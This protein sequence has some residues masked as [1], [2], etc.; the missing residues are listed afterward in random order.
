MSNAQN[1]KTSEQNRFPNLLLT[2]EFRP[3]CI[4]CSNL[5]L[6]CE[7]GRVFLWED[8]A[9]E[10]GI[11]FGRSKQNLGQNKGLP[12][13]SQLIA[14]R[15]VK[16]VQCSR[17]YHLFVNTTYG[18]FQDRTRTP[19]AVYSAPE[20]ARVLTRLEET[21][22]LTAEDSAALCYFSNRRPDL[23]YEVGVPRAVPD[24]EAV[25]FSYFVNRI[26][27]VCVCYPRQDQPTST[28][29]PQT[30]PYLY[31][32]APLAVRSAIVFQTIMAVLAKQLNLLGEHQ[33][34][35]AASNYTH[36]V[37]QTLPQLIKHKLATQLTDWDDVLA[38]VLMLCFTDILCSC[39]DNWIIHLNGAKNFLR[40]ANV[41]R[42]LL[43]V[44]DFF[45]RYFL[46]HEVMGQ[47]AWALR[48]VDE[49]PFMETLKN[50]H[51]NR[52][53]PVMGLLPSLVSLVNKISILGRCYESLGRYSRGEAFRASEI[54]ISRQRDAI[55][56]E[57]LALDQVMDMGDEKDPSHGY[58][59]IVAEI[60][61]L[62]AVVYLFGRIDLEYYHYN[63][64]NLLILRKHYDRYSRAV[65]TSRKAIALT[66]HL[67]NSAAVS[68]IWPYFVLGLV[69][70]DSET[71]RWY[72]LDQLVKME[73]SR[74]L[75]SVKAA[76]RAVESVWREKDLELASGPKTVVNFV[77]W[78]DMTRGRTDTISLA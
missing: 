49:D 6:A 25:L 54:I 68:L 16:W 56:A 73:R 38:T 45:I 12:L 53:D 1:T 74:E 18:D 76:R 65:A 11:S 43:P 40:D 17:E 22:P 67:P 47:T 52:I 62:T 27:P 58:T 71:D 34:Q 3:F 28:N 57:L 44:K 23:T 42:S 59:R 4:N 21:R 41:K 64:H 70:V 13:L 9:R 5:G 51:D 24:L 61:R 30:N 26:C 29:N 46:T 33:Y 2:A 36:I 31:L 19:L 48:H 35:T 7:Y 50:V 77:R 8:E 37:L 20:L 60:K 55:E 14:S 39:D 10:R 69:A 75:A 32:I 15:P 78:Q 66:R 63:R 72:V